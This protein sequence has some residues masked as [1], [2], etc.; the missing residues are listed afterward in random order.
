VAA[1]LSAP[2]RVRWTDHAVDKAALLGIT[3]LDVE[4]AVIQRHHVRQRNARSADWRI[5]DGRLVILYDHPD[6]G[7][8]ST[9]RIVTRWR[10]R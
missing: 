9:A 5:R 7:D 2:R 10:R 6:H 8:A 4:H 3:R 1:V